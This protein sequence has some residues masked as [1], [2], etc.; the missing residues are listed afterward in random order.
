[1]YSFN[2]DYLF[3]R[4][5]D[6]L[7][8]IKYVWFF[9]I[10]RKNPEDYLAR[11]E[12]REWDGLRDRGWF[13]DYFA[14]KDAV[15]PVVNNES[16]WQRMLSSLGLG[17]GDNDGDGIINLADKKPNDPNNLTSAEMKERFEQDYGFADKVR[18]MFGLPPKDTDGDGVPD[19]YER[20]H[21]LN[22]KH[23][24]TDKDNLSDGQELLAGTD[25]LNNDTD[26]DL[27]LDG[28]DEAPLD[29]TVSANGADSDGDGVS[30][31]IEKLL[32]T[33]IENRDSDGDGIPD[34]MDTYPLDPNNDSTYI[35]PDFRGAI[36]NVQTS[37]S[38]PFL[39]FV[40]DVLS[41]LAVFTIGILV[42]VVMLFVIKLWSSLKNYE[43]H[44]ESNDKEEKDDDL[45]KYSGDHIGIPGLAVT[46]EPVLTKQ[47]GLVDPPTNEEF[48]NHPRWAIVEGY[49]S[50]NVEALWRIGVMEA[51]NML[52]EVLAEKGYTGEDVGE[53][54][55]SARFKTVQ[56]A[57]DAHLVR[58]KI[59]HEGSSYTLTAREAK[60]VFA[61]YESV[62]IEL[63]AIR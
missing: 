26:R 18:D 43:R 58:N 36:D 5:Y 56:L 38:N 34:G 27:V 41:I 24:D 19:S 17:K 37:I 63:G 51:D 50:S 59:A 21:G 32:G 25:P 22:P 12:N 3:N 57:W 1:M 2:I 46:E 52:R 44:F 33:D 49:M 40:S 16:L 11:H 10:L 29:G 30:D 7:L 20:A 42:I 35:L 60:R 6:G 54:L 55:M 53:M 39:S 61:L 13:D 8:W 14:Q 31:A 4:V 62:F 28:R 9:V 48:E 15:I 45:S 47:G 23:P